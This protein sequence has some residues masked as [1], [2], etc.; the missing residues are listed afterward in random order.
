MAIVV[1]CENCRETLKVADDMAGRRGKCPNCKQ[2]INVPDPRHGW[3]PPGGGAM[4]PIGANAPATSIGQTVRCAGCGNGLLND[5]QLAG[6]MVEC[7]H[8]RAQMQMP[9]LN[10]QFHQPHQTPLPAAPPQANAAEFELVSEPDRISI[11]RPAAT[12]RK[13]RAGV[14]LGVC[15]WCIAPFLWLLIMFISN[16]GQAAAN[17]AQPGFQ[18]GGGGGGAN[19][20]LYMTLFSAGL[21]AAAFAYGVW[22]SVGIIMGFGLDRA[23]TVAEELMATRA[24]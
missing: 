5:P 20:G 9:P 2:K 22:C 7:P 15:L 16:L 19:H 12:A 1:T 14:W 8:C 6:Q 23:I 18:G 3:S 10:G 17:P 13:A 11:N 4:P 24:G 21:M